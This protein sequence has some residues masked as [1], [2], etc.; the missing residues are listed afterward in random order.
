MFCMWRATVCSLIQQLGGDGAVALARGDGRNTC[1]SRSVSRSWAAAPSSCG[2]YRARQRQ[3][4]RR[5]PARGRLVRLR[6][7]RAE[8]STDRRVPG[9]PDRFRTRA[10][11]S[12]VRCLKLTPGV[13]RSC[14]CDQRRS[15]L[16]LGQQHRPVA[17]RD[18]ASSSG[19]E[20]SRRRR[21][22]HRRRP[23]RSPIHRVGQL[24]LHARCQQFR[25]GHRL[26]GL[27]KTCADRG[28]AAPSTS[29]WRQVQQG[30][31]RQRRVTRT[32]RLR[33]RRSRP[34]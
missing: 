15:G 34:A 33:G 2:T 13:H 25:P 5:A 1:S 12:F 20:I 28:V 29:S 30:E 11:A 3:G 31:P 7:T 27:L 16:A 19:I 21:P 10:R 8:P 4:G 23:E 9:V 32:C 6:R 24:N 17:A 14:K 26:A 22:A 18:T